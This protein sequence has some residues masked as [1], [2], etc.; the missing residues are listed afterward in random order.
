MVFTVK[1]FP[2]TTPLLHQAW[3]FPGAFEVDQPSLCKMLHR[4]T[5]HVLHQHA[6]VSWAMEISSIYNIY[7]FL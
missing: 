2:E 5:V 4:A 7:K 1:M 6:D 3:I